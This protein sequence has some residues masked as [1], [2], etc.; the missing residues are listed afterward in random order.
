MP[1]VSIPLFV[2][3]T[4]A[5]GL[6]PPAV[7]VVYFVGIPITLPWIVYGSWIKITS[8]S[9]SVMIFIKFVVAALECCKLICRHLISV[10]VAPVLI[11]YS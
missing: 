10:S 1:L 9:S 4:A 8:S 3:T 7:K 2:T 11:F 6:A 5:L